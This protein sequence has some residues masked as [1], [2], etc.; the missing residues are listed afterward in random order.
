MF[1]PRLPESARDRQTTV[2][3]ITPWWDQVDWWLRPDL[4]YAKGLADGAA[5]ER[6]RQEAA[7]DQA[8]R[9]AVRT[10][11]RVIDT[12]DARRVADRGERQRAA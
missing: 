1:V 9:E 8:W 4:I 10:A 6:A 3:E 2:D 12:A 7:D 5:L 11:I